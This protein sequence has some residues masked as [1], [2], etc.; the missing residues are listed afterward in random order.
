M[1]FYFILFYFLVR[2]T[3][4][5]TFLP[6]PQIWGFPLSYNGGLAACWDPEEGMV[7]RKRGNMRP[8]CRKGEEGGLACP[9]CI[10]Q[11]KC[12]LWSI[13]YI[14]PWRAEQSNITSTGKPHSLDTSLFQTRFLSLCL[15]LSESLFKTDASS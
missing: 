8:A 10:A 7:R 4:L 1:G 15:W 14:K 13:Y 3:S 9:P 11:G 6:S 5:F 12:D 2:A